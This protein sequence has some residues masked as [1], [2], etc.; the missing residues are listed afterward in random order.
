[1]DERTDLFL[2]YCWGQKSSRIKADLGLRTGKKQLTVRT[3]SAWIK[4]SQKGLSLLAKQWGPSWKCSSRSWGTICWVV[5]V[6]IP[7]LGRS[8]DEMTSSPLP[9]LK[10]HDFMLEG[11]GKQQPR[12]LFMSK[13]SEHLL[14]CQCCLSRMSHLGDVMR[15]LGGFRESLGT[16]VLPCLIDFFPHVND[17]PHLKGYSGTEYSKISRQWSRHRRPCLSLKVLGRF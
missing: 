12:G 2:S 3:V 10:F 4:L 14:K 7:A 13:G 1:M 5:R 6:R 11:W 15:P 9:S 17:I 16:S 8:W